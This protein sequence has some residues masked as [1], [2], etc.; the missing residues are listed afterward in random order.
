MS[1][2]AEKGEVQEPQERNL[3]RVTSRR[4][5]N[6]A[7]MVCAHPNASLGQKFCSDCGQE[8]NGP[9]QK[10]VEEVVE[11]V[12]LRHGLIP[13]EGQGKPDPDAPLRQ[14]Y[15]Q[16]EAA[17]RKWYEGPRYKDF[18]EFK[19]ASTEER[20]KELAKHGIKAPWIPKVSPRIAVG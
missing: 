6:H 10:S 14:A 18:A 8:L 11:K 3:D 4:E 7:S 9:S 16:Y 13:G 17:P 1:S 5:S 19:A 15:E 12:L 20:K 2:E